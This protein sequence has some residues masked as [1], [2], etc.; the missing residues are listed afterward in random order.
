[1]Y[2]RCCLFI[3]FLDKNQGIRKEKGSLENQSGKENLL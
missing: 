2:N 3:Y 1:M